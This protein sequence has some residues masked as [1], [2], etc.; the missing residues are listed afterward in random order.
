MNNLIS[1]PCP[2]FMRD[3]YEYIKNILS[4]ISL[5]GKYYLN[6]NHKERLIEAC[7]NNFKQILS[8]PSNCIIGTE[9]SSFSALIYHLRNIPNDFKIV[10][11]V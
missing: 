4:E 2:M 5:C 1:Y 10:G 3:Y 8:I 6:H 9:S 11:G 7:N